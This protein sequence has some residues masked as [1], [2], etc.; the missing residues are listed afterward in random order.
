MERMTYPFTTIAIIYNPN[1]TGNSRQNAK[2]LEKELIAKL[3]EYLKIRRIPTKHAGHGEVIA[4]DLAKK[5]KKILI[6]S[7]SGD[8]GYNEVVN[9]IIAANNPNAACMVLPSGNA[10]D[11][12]EATADRSVLERFLEPKIVKVDVVKVTGIRDGKNWERYAHSYVG[13]GLTAYI[14]KKLTEA[15]LNPVNEKWLV[16]KHLLLFRSVKLKIKP[17]RRWHKYSSVVFGNINRMSKVIKL[18]DNSRNDDGKMEMY[19]LRTKSLTK[20]LY[21][22]LFA[23]T[24]GMQPN[25]QGKVVRFQAKKPV[26]IQLDGE[27][28]TLDATK[29]VTIR[30]VSGAVGT[31]L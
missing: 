26:E 30:L 11:H 27:V 13:V 29:E 6:V 9:G 18:G 16:L 1:S 31:V 12:H 4:H 21:V 24:L 8:G 25:F 5:H 22:L 19:V 28:C 3:P 17:G 10:N 15:D 20:T 23:S 2:S 14:G 7:S